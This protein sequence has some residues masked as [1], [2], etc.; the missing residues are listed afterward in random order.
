MLGNTHTPL[1]W[2][3]KHMHYGGILASTPLTLF[4]KHLVSHLYAACLLRSCRLLVIRLQEVAAAVT[5]VTPQLFCSAQGEVTSSYIIY[6][7]CCNMITFV[8]S[9]LLHNIVLQLALFC[10][11]YTASYLLYKSVHVIKWIT[12]RAVSDCQTN[13][14]AAFS[15]YF[16]YKPLPFGYKSQLAFLPILFKT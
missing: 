10:R 13:N 14:F 16:P 7:L 9:C 15:F 11:H 6:D 1:L 12:S 4:D 2:K 8:C 5:C 3:R